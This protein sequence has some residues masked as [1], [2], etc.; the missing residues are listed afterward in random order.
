MIYAILYGIPMVFITLISL[1]M[2]ILLLK[3]MN[4]LLTVVNAV[5]TLLVK[6]KEI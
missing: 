1:A 4:G 5:L 6:V 3:G 2:P